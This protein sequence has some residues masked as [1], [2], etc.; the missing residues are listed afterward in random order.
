MNY[1]T[2]SIDKVIDLTNR[3]FKESKEVDTKHLILGMKEELIN[4]RIALK[5]MKKFDE[6][7]DT[8][9]I[10]KY[11]KLLDLLYESA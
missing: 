6:K 5:M 2:N 10:V 9:D 7:L 8:F 4:I 11:G 1:I 3:A